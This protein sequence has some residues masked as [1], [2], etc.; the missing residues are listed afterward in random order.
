MTPNRPPDLVLKTIELKDGIAV[1]PISSGQDSTLHSNDTATGAP[2]FPS[3]HVMDC[4]PD[5]ARLAELKDLYGLGDEVEYLKRY[6]RFSRRPEQTFLPG[7]AKNEGFHKIQLSP[8]SSLP[9]Q[10]CDKPLEVSVTQSPFPGNVDLSG[11]IFGVSTTINRFNHPSTIEHWTFWLTDGHGKSNGGRLILRLVDAT[12]PQLEDVAQ[13]LADAG[14]D[15][16]VGA[17]DSR[18]EKPMAKRYFN[19]APLLYQADPNRKWFVVC[20]DDTFFTAINGL[21]T[22]LQRFDHTKP[23]YIGALS[24][25]MH[26]I[27][28]HGSH[29]YGGAGVFLSRALAETIYNVRD[30]CNTRAKVRQSNSGYGSQGDILLRLCID[31]NANVRLVPLRDLWQLDLVGD[32]SGFFEAGFKPHSVHHFKGGWWFTAY[33]LESTKIAHT[34]GEDCLFQR[35]IT[36]DN[37]IISNGYSIAQ[38]PEGI[39]FNLD[40][41]EH[42]FRAISKDRGNNFDLVFGPQ[43]PTLSRTGR[44]IAWELRESNVDE[45]DGSVVQVYVRKKDDKRWMTEDGKRMRG[46]AGIIELVWVAE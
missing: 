7:D 13:R 26:A 30:T 6:V 37:F 3:K 10:E 8:G 32:G 42:T 2:R 14:I 38:Y 1:K 16:E 39:D 24:E 9:K 17:W 15:A 43:R 46:L 12:D 31:D 21:V 28:V 25:D 33:P 36:T 44:K 22:S 41:V 29:A 19:I 34:C 18:V 23:F 4:S 20:D 45:E 35:F 5:A 27:S 40:Q 11:Y